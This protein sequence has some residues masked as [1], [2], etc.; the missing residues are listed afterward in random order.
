MSRVI[1][2]IYSASDRRTTKSFFVLWTLFWVTFTLWALRFLFYRLC[3]S[4]FGLGRP[5]WADLS[6]RYW[7]NNQFSNQGCA[8]KSNTNFKVCG[9]IANFDLYSAYIHFH[10]LS[11]SLFE[12]S[13][14]MPLYLWFPKVFFLATFG[15][16]VSFGTQSEASANV[17]L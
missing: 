17:F 6:S 15:F 16:C 9:S 10:K 4:L 8:I 7:L 1:K 13:I 11:H 14:Q 12:K 2:I 5:E 3:T